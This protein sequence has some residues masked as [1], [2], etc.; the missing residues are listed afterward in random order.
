MGLVERDH[1]SIDEDGCDLIVD[2]G[3]MTVEAE[4]AMVR[5]TLDAGGSGGID[6]LRAR[7]RAEASQTDWNRR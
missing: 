6:R 7:A 3:A 2:S 5:D 1:A 4:V